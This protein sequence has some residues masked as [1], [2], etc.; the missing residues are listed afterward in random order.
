MNLDLTLLKQNIKLER[1]KK[2]AIRIVDVLAGMERI[3]QS[4]AM[5][6]LITKIDE[7]IYQSMCS[8]LNDTYFGDQ[9]D[10]IICYAL[11]EKIDLED[12]KEIEDIISKAIL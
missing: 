4:D 1:I 12:K 8:H 3:Q 2:M 7:T 9:D 11:L 5:N 6:S 10:F